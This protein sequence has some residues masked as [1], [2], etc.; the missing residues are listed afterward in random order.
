MKSKK[1]IPQ[2]IQKLLNEVNIDYFLFYP[3]K[4]KKK[5]KKLI[6]NKKSINQLKQKIFF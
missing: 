5:K 4:K 2:F 3:K 1:V 6:K